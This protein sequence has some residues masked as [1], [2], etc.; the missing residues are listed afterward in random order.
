MQTSIIEEFYFEKPLSEKSIE[1]IKQLH[2][3]V[4]VKNACKI[5]FNLNELD[6]EKIFDIL[7][8]NGDENTSIPG[9]ETTGIITN[10]IIKLNNF[11]KSQKVY[12]PVEVSKQQTQKIQQTED[13]KQNTQQTEV[14]KSKFQIEDSKQ[15]TDQLKL[16][17]R[18]PQQKALEYMETQQKHFFQISCGCGKTYIFKIFYELH[19]DKHFLIVVPSI[20]LAEQLIDGNKYFDSETSGKYW[21]GNKKEPILNKSGGSVCICVS[22]SFKNIP[23]N[24]INRLNFI[25]CDEAHH[26]YLKNLMEPGF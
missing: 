3:R 2:F 5:T 23:D 19:Q 12:K 24:I 26:D 13:S 25:I 20:N 11:I 18:E 1:E 9:N 4:H 14:F 8:E 16:E 17:L 15:L 6:L 7:I 22:N 10:S 21:T